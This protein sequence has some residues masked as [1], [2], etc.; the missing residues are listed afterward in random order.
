LPSL[1]I[2]K[3]SHLN[4]A[5]HR[6]REIYQKLHAALATLPGTRPLFETL[7]AQTVPWVYPLYVN[8]PK[9]HFS[10]LKMQGV[11]IWRFGEFLAAEVTPEV[12]PV[13][14]DYSEHVFQFPCH[15]SL[16]D[17]DIDWM[18]SCITQTLAVGN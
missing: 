17:Q 15:Q 18:I 8:Q 16:T 12:C 11:P 10:R 3:L 1:S 5:A 2:I 7:P 14:I 9:Q 4:N 13:S 6:R